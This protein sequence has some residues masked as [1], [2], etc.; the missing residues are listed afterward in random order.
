[1]T[2]AACSGAIE[3]HLGS[4]DGI[5]SINVSLMTN[6]AIIRHDQNLIRPRKIIEEIE[7]LGFDAE[8]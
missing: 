1:M 3:R 4:T 5:K 6:K 2:C 7:D 8:L